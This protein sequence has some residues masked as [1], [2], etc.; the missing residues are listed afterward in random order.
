MKQLISALAS[1]LA[2]AVPCVLVEVVRVQGSTP[3]EVGAAMLVTPETTL[4]TIGGGKL[5]LMAIDKAHA[6]IGSGWCEAA[7]AAALE[8]RIVLSASAGQCCGGVAS[9]RYSVADPA[10][11]RRLREQDAQTHRLPTMLFGNGHVAQ[12]LV[13][14]LACLPVRLSWV[15]ERGAQFPAD[16][17]HNV[18]V[19]DTDTPEAEV[20]NA[21][22]DTAFL[23]MTHSHAL[24]ERL[25]HAI[26]QKN[27]FSYF[28]LIGSASKRLNFERRLA[29]RGIDAARLKKMRCPIG[30]AGIKD[31]RPEVIAVSVAAQLMQV[32]G[33]LYS[34]GEDAKSKPVCLPLPQ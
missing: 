13:R 26:L 22:D 27:A 1:N 31:K 16:A 15:D 7:D 23:V 24:D 30:I 25:C 9:L 10:T 33:A 8:D 17:P 4:G 6:L 14:V 5:E 29:M 18:L 2:M 21:A 28:G 34:L 12:A 32:H 11:L 20:E 3:R 19:I